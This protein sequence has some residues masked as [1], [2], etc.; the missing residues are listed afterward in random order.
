MG[1][2][3]KFFSINF[4]PFHKKSIVY[5]FTLKLFLSL[6]LSLSLCLSLEW[7]SSIKINQ[8]IASLVIPLSP[9]YVFLLIYVIGWMLKARPVNFL[10]TIFLGLPI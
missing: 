2:N 4:G 3:I 1:V 7:A 6:S 8:I 9:N 10:G 5:H